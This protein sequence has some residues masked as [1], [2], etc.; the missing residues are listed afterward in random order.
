MRAER[1]DAAS[2]GGGARHLFVEEHGLCAVGLLVADGGVIVG[3]G[4]VVRTLHLQVAL[5]RLLEG[6]ARAVP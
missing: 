3:G 1:R 4:G 2:I 6:C 5:R